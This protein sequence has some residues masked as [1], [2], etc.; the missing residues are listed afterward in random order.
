MASPALQQPKLQAL[1]YSLL[2]LFDNIPAPTIAIEPPEHFGHTDTSRKRRF[3]GLQNAHYEWENETICFCSHCLKTVDTDGLMRHELVHAWMKAQGFTLAASYKHKYPF[4]HKAH[5][6][7]AVNCH[8]AD[9]V[10]PKKRYAT[11][12]WLF[13]VMGLLGFLAALIFRYNVLKPMSGYMLQ[14]SVLLLIPASQI[15]ILIFFLLFGRKF[16]KLYYWISL[17]VW[18]PFAFFLEIDW[19]YHFYDHMPGPDEMA[20][21]LPVLIPM[22]F[23]LLISGIAAVFTGPEPS[24]ALILSPR[25]HTTSPK[26]KREEVEDELR[27]LRENRKAGKTD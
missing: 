13:G 2:H 9:I 14:Y 19:L 23:V 26:T 11:A 6:V 15:V 16:N 8:D 10:W 3:R 22:S 20:R 21:M 12:N 5:Q 18:F 1:C 27:R 17:R 7:G 4:A 25:S 24:E